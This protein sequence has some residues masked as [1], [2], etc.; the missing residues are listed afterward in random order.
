[1][2]MTFNGTGIKYYG[3]TDKMEDGSYVATKWITILYLPVIPIGSTR[4]RL[5]S[6]GFD[7]IVYSTQSFY[8]EKV[9]L[10]WRQ[11]GKTYLTVFGGFFT[12]FAVVYLWSVL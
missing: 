10:H 5:V 9:P 11:V 1:M 8:M 7:V 12:L 4:M 3:S 2:A 6:K